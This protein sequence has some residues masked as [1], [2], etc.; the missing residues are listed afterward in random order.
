MVARDW[1]KE[2]SEMAKNTGKGSRK[3]SI[4]DR[5]QM[6]DPERGH[7]SIFKASSGTFLRTKKSPGPEKGIRKGVPKKLGGHS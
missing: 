7:W 1:L 5:F 4:A 2:R 6:L 3:G